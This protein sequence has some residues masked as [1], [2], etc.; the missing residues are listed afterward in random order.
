MSLAHD[1]SVQGATD[2]LTAIAASTDGLTGQD[3]G[4]REELL[5]LARQLTVALET[6]SEAIQ[7]MGWAEVCDIT[8]FYKVQILTMYRLPHS[9]QLEWQ[10]TWKFST[11]L[12]KP[13]VLL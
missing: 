8:Q 3:P 4:A 1:H 7:R 5:S 12:K 2:I 13:T 6:P 9:Q 11:S 10:W